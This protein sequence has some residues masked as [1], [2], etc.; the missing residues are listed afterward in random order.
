MILQFPALIDQV[1]E[2]FAVLEIPE[3]ELDKL[4]HAI[5]D[6]AASQPGLDAEALRQHLVQ[7]GF[8][9]TVEALLL[10]SVDTGFLARRSDPSSV[11]NEW[12]HVIKMLVGEDHCGLAEAGNNLIKDVSAE[13][14]DRLLAARERAD[15]EGL[16]GDD[17]I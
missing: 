15:Q 11:R 7:N 10:P 2:E 8:A 5:L 9:A 4:R 14:W 3:L 1:V 17:Q 16:V 13:N 12:A 6:V